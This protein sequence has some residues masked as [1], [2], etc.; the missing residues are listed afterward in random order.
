MKGLYTTDAGF[1]ELASRWWELAKSPVTVQSRIF[2]GL[3]ESLPCNSPRRAITSPIHREGRLLQAV[4]VYGHLGQLAGQHEILCP[5]GGAAISSSSK[6]L[7]ET[8]PVTIV[9]QAKFCLA[10][11]FWFTVSCNG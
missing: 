7:L 3:M 9:F 6:Q 8:L 1:L 5:N 11:H 4:R 10:N 2:K